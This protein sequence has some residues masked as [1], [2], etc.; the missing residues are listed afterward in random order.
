[1]SKLESMRCCSSTTR[2]LLPF[3]LCLSTVWT[4]ALG[5]VVWILKLSV[6][7]VLGK[8][9]IGQR[10]SW[11]ERS[12]SLAPL[13]R[14][15]KDPQS[16]TPKVLVLIALFGF[17]RRGRRGC[18]CRR[19]QNLFDFCSWL[20][21]PD[22]VLVPLFLLCFRPQFRLASGNILLDKFALH[23]HSCFYALSSNSASARVMYCSH[24]ISLISFRFAICFR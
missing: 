22:Y 10:L 8:L 11:R 23:A 12:P 6:F 24:K 1:M 15:L 21:L 4:C 5:W 14:S 7:G 17:L 18:R 2:W 13:Q 16:S 3:L 20:R 9:A 19:R